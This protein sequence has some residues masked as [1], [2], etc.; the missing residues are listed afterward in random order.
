MDGPKCL[1]RS[2]PKIAFQ[3]N[4]IYNIEKAEDHHY[5]EPHEPQEKD[6]NRVFLICNLMNKIMSNVLYKKIK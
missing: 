1:K 5:E 3:N 2:P 4:D 6:N